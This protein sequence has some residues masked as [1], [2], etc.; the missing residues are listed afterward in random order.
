M[1]ASTNIVFFILLIFWFA[2]ILGEKFID[3]SFFYFFGIFFYSYRE[4][5]FLIQ[6]QYRI[7]NKIETCITLSI[8]FIID[9]IDS[10]VYI[11]QIYNYFKF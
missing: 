10:S 7:L 11:S 6:I 1:L 3:F 4:I 5:W 9:F 8:I 2:R